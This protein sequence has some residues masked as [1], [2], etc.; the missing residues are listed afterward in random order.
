MTKKSTVNKLLPYMEFV[1]AERDSMTSKVAEL[2]KLIES[3]SFYGFSEKEQILL[4]RQQSIM[5]DL[6]AVLNARIALN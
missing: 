3:E 2:S 4:T 1:V 6:V 5:N